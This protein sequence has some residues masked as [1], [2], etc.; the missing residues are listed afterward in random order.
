[1]E[2]VVPPRIH[3]FDKFFKTLFPFSLDNKP[4][5]LAKEHSCLSPGHIFTQPLDRA[6][7]DPL[8]H[9]KIHYLLRYANKVARSRL[10]FMDDDLHIA[11]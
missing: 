11:I 6:P 8:P 4:V 3:A 10:N 7:N 5:V 2:K 9:S 1:M